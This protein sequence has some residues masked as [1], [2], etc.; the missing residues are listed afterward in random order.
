MSD[1]C[2]CDHCGKRGRRPRMHAAPDG[3][4]YLEAVDDEEGPSSAIIVLACSDTCALALWK[5][6]RG[7]RFDTVPETSADDGGEQ[8]VR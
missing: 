6:G 8:H 3:W 1:D 4:L 7:P 2:K 5:P